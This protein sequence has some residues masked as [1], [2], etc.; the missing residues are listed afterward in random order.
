MHFFPRVRVEVWFI[1]DT[2]FD[3][4]LLK[5]NSAI[6]KSWQVNHLVRTKEHSAYHYCFESEN[7]YIKYDQ[8]M[9]RFKFRDDLIGH[10]FAYLESPHF[11]NGKQRSYV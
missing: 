3:F 6:N 9:V 11:H 2:V 10:N 7:E 4:G 1:L 8:N 5:L